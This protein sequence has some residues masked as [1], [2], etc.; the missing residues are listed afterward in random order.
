MREKVRD[1][2]RLEHILEAIES[3]E[4]FHAQ[5]TFQ[6]IKKNKLIFYGFTKLV[7]VIGEAVYMLSTEFRDSHSDVNWR[8]IERMRHVLVHGYYTIDPES[9]WDTIE[10]D[11]P[12]LKPWIVRYLLRLRNVGANWHRL[13]R[14]DNRLFY[15]Q[16]TYHHPKVLEASVG[17]HLLQ[18]RG[19]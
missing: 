15:V 4:E 19:I 5:Y 17:S 8:Q 11:I 16:V 14:V 3:I 13:F 2:G 18:C 10:V 9:L 1:R 7:E 6:D 12:E